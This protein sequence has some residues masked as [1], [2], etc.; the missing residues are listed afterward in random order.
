MIK[1]ITISELN[2]INTIK[3]EDE[4][5]KADQ[6]QASDECVNEINDLLKRYWH[7]IGIESYL[8]PIKFHHGYTA[9]HHAQQLFM[10]EGFEMSYYQPHG[11]LSIKNVKK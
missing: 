7:K 6:E 4:Y 3:N 9:F 10:K 11:M 2:K 8:I 1:P 5:D